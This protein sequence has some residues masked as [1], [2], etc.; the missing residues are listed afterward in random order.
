MGWADSSLEAPEAGEMAENVYMDLT[1]ASAHT[2]I[3][4]A[5]QR[6]GAERFVWG[7]DQPYLTFIGEFFKLLSLRIPDEEKRGILW[8]NPKRIYRTT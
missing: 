4:R 6:L 8:Q 1:A 3:E 2:Y 5:I 7:T